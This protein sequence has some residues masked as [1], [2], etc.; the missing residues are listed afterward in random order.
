MLV[1]ALTCGRVSKFYNVFNGNAVGREQYGLA[2]YLQPIGLQPGRLA[3][4]SFQ[5]NF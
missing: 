5:F 1:A 4:V 3:K 2:N